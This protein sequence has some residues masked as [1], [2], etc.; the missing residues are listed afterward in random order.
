[1]DTIFN[2]KATIHSSKI[3]ISAILAVAI[4]ALIA[5]DVVFAQGAISAVEV[6][7]T[8]L[9][10]LWVIICAMLIFG[11]Q[12]GFL[13]FTLGCIREKNTTVVALKNVGDWVVVTIVYFL[14][15]FA[16]NFGLSDSSFIG[17]GFFLGNGLDEPRE[18]MYFVF[19]LAF[20]G[21]SA[22]I[23]SGAMAERTSFKAYLAFMICMGCFIYP[24]FSYWVWGNGLVY[25][26]QPWLQQ[27]GFRDFAGASVV[28]N[29][30]G[31][32][33]L[34]GAWIVGPRIGRY[35]SDGTLCNL[36]R[37][38]SPYWLCVGTFILWVGWWGF[39]GGSFLEWNEQVPGVILNT[40]IA[41]AVGG[42]FAFSHC[43]LFQR[44]EDLYAKSIGGILGGLVA[45]TACADV[46]SPVSATVIGL[47]AGIIHN[48]SYDLVLKKLRLDDVVAAVP[49]H[50]FCGAWGLLCVALFGKPESL[51]AGS[52][53]EQLLSQV[54]G[55]VVCFAW[56]VGTSLL[57]FFLIKSSVG[58]RVPAMH[59]IRGLKVSELDSDEDA[60]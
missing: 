57:C 13:C 22:T 4:W 48:L 32:S 5:P 12:L 35:K 29:I 30:G 47:L 46:V 49:V 9:D 21:T 55:I 14:F 16:I 24:M 34:V 37:T 50:G 40:N 41:G 6:V 51:P 36:E 52:M 20:A 54:I 31:W 17:K 7:S 1:M 26:N 25:S 10:M 3:A 38:N 39:N 8:R 42:I 56:S 58:I 15:G 53:L 43:C 11:M 60:E 2:T 18:I 27:L 28:H 19:Q 33:S 44:N 59:E 23:V 45:I